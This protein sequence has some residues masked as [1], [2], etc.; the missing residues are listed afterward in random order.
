MQMS[1]RESQPEL[2]ACRKSCARKSIRKHSYAPPDFGRPSDDLLTLANV[3]GIGKDFVGLA[4][5]VA[6]LPVLDTVM[7]ESEAVPFA[8]RSRLPHFQFVVTAPTAIYSLAVGALFLFGSSGLPPSLDEAVGGPS[9]R[10]AV[11][12]SSF[13][14]HR[15][16]LSSGLH[17]ITLRT[18]NF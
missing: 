15:H 17:V 4:M 13:S 14:C 10:K 3:G 2:G 5:F 12:G 8:F 11:P 9:G 16:V 6:G 7:T 18:N 1:W